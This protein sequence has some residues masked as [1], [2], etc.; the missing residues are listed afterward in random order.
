[1]PTE[2]FVVRTSCVR[3]VI[4]ISERASDRGPRPLRGLG[5]PSEHNSLSGSG[6]PHPGTKLGCS[7]GS[8]PGGYSVVP[9]ACGKGPSRVEG[10]PGLDALPDIETELLDLRYVSL[11]QARRDR[12]AIERPT[13]DL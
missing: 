3:T 9:L 12:E 13:L 6:I 1:M 2:A 10:N 11:S 5:P 8:R 7:T 4:R